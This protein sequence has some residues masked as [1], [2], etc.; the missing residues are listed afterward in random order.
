M[1]IVI[2]VLFD[3]ARQQLCVKLPIL[4][5]VN[6][7]LTHLRMESGKAGLYG[8]PYVLSAAYGLYEYFSF[9]GTLLNK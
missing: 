9:L 6:S 2:A 5:S 8:F 3:A 1:F 7:S 4:A